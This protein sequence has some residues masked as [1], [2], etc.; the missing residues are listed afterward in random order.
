[1]T[2]EGELRDLEVSGL[3]RLAQT[4]P[5]LER[6]A[7]RDVLDGLGVLGLAIAFASLASLS[8][9]QAKTADSNQASASDSGSAAAAAIAP[10]R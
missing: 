3:I 7:I 2:V 8:A 1:M 5:E 6:P 10:R 4:E 9:G